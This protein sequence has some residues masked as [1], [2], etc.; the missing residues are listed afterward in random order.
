MTED[1]PPPDEW[2]ASDGTHWFW[3]GGKINGWTGWMPHED[4][5]W[6]LTSEE[7]RRSYPAAPAWDTT[8]GRER[9]D[10]EVPTT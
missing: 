2:V 3:T 9:T 1:D 6:F 10:H 5:H 7:F 8:N 4:G